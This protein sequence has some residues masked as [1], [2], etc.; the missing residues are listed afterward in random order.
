MSPAPAVAGLIGRERELAR[1]TESLAESR[2]VTL[3]G[4]G[5]IGKTWLATAAAFQRDRP[6]ETWFVDLA[7]AGDVGDVLTA[8]G[9]AIGLIIADHRSAAVE[10]ERYLADRPVLLVLDAVER[11]AGLASVIDGWTDRLPAVR[12]LAT[13]RMPIGAD[14]E[15]EMPITGLALPRGDLAR[16]VEASPAGALFLR[17]ARQLGTLAELDDDSARDL[18]AVLRRLDG[19]P[20]AIEL[21][22]GR[23][24]VLSPGSLLRRLAVRS[25]VGASSASPA[26]PAE[27][28]RHASLAGVLDMTVGLL[29][30]DA[31]RLLAR[32]AVC[33]GSFDLDLAQALQPTTPV[34]PTMDVLVA[35]GVIRRTGQ[36][37]GEPR[38]RQLETL[39]TYELVEAPTAELDT[40]RE[41]HA[42]AVG[43]IV[44]RVA[45]RWTTDE[46]GAMQVIVT[47]DDNIA[48]AI[49][50]SVEHDPALGLAILSVIDR[51]LQAGVKLDRSVRWHRALLAVAARDDPARAIA[52][53]SL[54]RLL[55][56][57]TGTVEAL[58]MAPEVELEAANA[59]G[60]V[61]RTLY[62]RLAYLFHAVGDP[63]EAA[64][65]NDLAAASSTDSDDGEALRLD[66]AATRAWLSGDLPLAAD[67]MG[68]STAAH[69]RAGAMS[70]AGIASFKR[71]LIELHAGLSSAAEEHARA[72][73]ARCPAGNLRAFS[74]E[75]LAL[76][77]AER[78]SPDGARDALTE[79]W[80][81]VQWEAPIDRLEA[82]DAAVAVL[83]AEDRHAEALGALA[84]AD[85]GRPDTGW[86]RDPHVAVILERW[87]L[88]ATRSLTTVSVG[89]AID[90]PPGLTVEAAIVGALA[91]PAPGSRPP[92]R[93][94]RTRD[95]LTAREVEVF[96]LVGAGRS[97]SEISAA[98]FISRKTASVHVTNIKSKLGVG[99]RLE[100][101]LLA[102]EMGLGSAPSDTPLN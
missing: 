70:N 38:F 21:A 24:R 96:A 79:A 78:G 75:V 30:T 68:R 51:Y 29:G 32:L 2:L 47:E 43:V 1:L 72:A 57:Y 36:L 80:A 74:L 50:W 90:P 52:A 98:L 23:S 31:R 27:T 82:L 16:D 18:A 85:R 44:E 84:V 100:I 92:S 3:A 4:P 83:A 95:G 76:A 10:V 33:P 101:A 77:L 26:H 53:G 99:S 19:I 49:D 8:V 65:C 46:P 34:V 87:R 64:R 69:E 9:W 62:L 54:L 14:H 81:V 59:S 66:S 12:V 6:I 56:R 73:V 89:L 22:A 61:R 15:V 40:A 71:A 37:D 48:A 97:D 45:G 67:L 63:L 20:L 7:E 28:A 94:P 39:R 86:V 55:T 41:A 60:R 17:R 25:V 35:A 5:G 88:R 11:V 58:A 13:S 91:K 93:V 102:R 42:R